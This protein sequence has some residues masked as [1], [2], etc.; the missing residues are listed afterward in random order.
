MAR[1]IRPVSVPA[2]P[3]A[4]VVGRYGGIVGVLADIL[5]GGGVRVAGTAALDRGG[6]E[7]VRR[8][9][10]GR[11]GGVV[12]VSAAPSDATLSLAVEVVAP[13][14]L[15]A[16]TW[17]PP[18]ERPALPEGVAVV[19]AGRIHRDLADAVRARG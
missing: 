5:E 18:D 1:T 3:V 13:A 9:L 11:G 10:D 15:V 16:V 2:A 6:A 4:V 19:A 17:H 7:E 12:V 8:L 14:R